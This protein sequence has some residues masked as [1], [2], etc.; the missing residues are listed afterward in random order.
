MA[1]VPVVFGPVELLPDAAD[2]EVAL[3]VD[4]LVVLDDA[5]PAPLDGCEPAGVAVVDPDVPVPVVV[6]GDVL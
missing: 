4:G 3:S 5:V 1:D 2:A 6:D